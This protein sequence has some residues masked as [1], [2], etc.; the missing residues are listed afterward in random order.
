MFAEQLSSKR[1][2]FT[3]FINKNNIYSCLYKFK[4]ADYGVELLTAAEAERMPDAGVEFFAFAEV[5]DASAAHAAVEWQASVW[6]LTRRSTAVGV[7]HG[8]AGERTLVE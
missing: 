6:W 5:D 3:K 1:R 4:M 8:D 7:S 2:H